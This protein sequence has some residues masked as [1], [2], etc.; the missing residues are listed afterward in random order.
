MDWR[1]PIEQQKPVAAQDAPRPRRNG[2]ATRAD[3][4]RRA[5]TDPELLE[6][7]LQ[8]HAFTEQLRREGRKL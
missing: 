6:L 1:R 5:G 3:D 8:A 7:A 4:L 2:G